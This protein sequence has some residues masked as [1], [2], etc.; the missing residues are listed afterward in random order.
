[1]GKQ[2]VKGSL[3]F[4]LNGCCSIFRFFVLRKHFTE[5]LIFGIFAISLNIL[6]GQTGL[7]SLG[8]AAFS[9]LVP[10]QQVLLLV[11]YRQMCF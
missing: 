6:V 3:L 4:F 9:V 2:W 5:I 1:M 7:V 11:I 8:H 10:M